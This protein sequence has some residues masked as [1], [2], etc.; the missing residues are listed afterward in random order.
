[1]EEWLAERRPSGFHA[2]D[3]PLSVPFNFSTLPLTPV[4]RHLSHIPQNDSMPLSLD[5][6]NLLG[7]MHGFN[8]GKPM[9]PVFDSLQASIEPGTSRKAPAGGS[10]QVAAYGQILRQCQDLQKENMQLI[11]ENRTLKEVL[12]TMFNQKSSSPSQLVPKPETTQALSHKIS[13]DGLPPLPCLDRE[14][15][16]LIRFW[17]QQKWKKLQKKNTGITFVGDNTKNTGKAERRSDDDAVHEE[18][19]EVS[20]EEKDKDDDGLSSDSDSSDDDGDTKC[21]QRTVNPQIHYLQDR[22]GNT[23]TLVQFK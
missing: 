10:I 20:D 13:L 21:S 6:L 17:T 7:H 11:G 18:D 1:M 2:S 3:P 8:E 12:G 9:G 16:P 5:S 14:A 23:I 15:F 4:S 19:E 22:F